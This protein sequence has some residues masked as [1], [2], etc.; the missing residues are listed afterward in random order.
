MI[1]KIILKIK[2]FILYIFYLNVI[3]VFRILNYDFSNNLYL[4]L[5]SYYYDIV[6]LLKLL[7]LIID[8]L[9]E[10]NFKQKRKKMIAE[11]I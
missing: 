5:I 1:Y 6:W 2:F 7:G 4:W 11:K 8:I 3:F 10:F 9:W